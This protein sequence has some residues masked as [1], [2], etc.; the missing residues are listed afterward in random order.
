MSF[1]EFRQNKWVRFISNKYILILILFIV[2]MIFF[3]ANSYLI[4]HE[5]DNDINGLEDNA[6]FYQKEIDHDKTFI[7]KME[8]SNEMEKFAREKYYLKKENEDIYIIEH[9]DSI[10]KEEKR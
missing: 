10:K 2:W 6:E 1:S 5:L 4:H 8:D 3:D 7:K 9:E